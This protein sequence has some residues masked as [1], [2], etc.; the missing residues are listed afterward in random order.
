MFRLRRLRLGLLAQI[1]LALALVGTVPLAIAA[2]QLAD[3]NREALVEQLLRTHTVSARTAADAIDGFLAAR[4]SLAGALRLSPELAAD[5]TSEGGQARLRDSLASW[6]A[7][8]VVAAA[9]YDSSDR[10]IVKVQQK[11]Y[12]AL[13]DELLGSVEA[14]PSGLRTVDLHPWIRIQVAL[15]PEMA[16][17]NPPR[18]DSPSPAAPRPSAGSGTLRLAVDA[19]PLLR[20]LAPDELGD[21]AQLLLL[22]RGGKTLLGPVEAVAALPSALL[23]SALSARLSGSGRFRDRAGHEIVGAWSAADSG[24]WIVVSTQPAA[25]AEAAALRMRQRTVLVVALALALAAA[26]SIFAYRALVRPLR[27]LLAAQR[28]VAGL[29]GEPARGSEVAQLKTTMEALERNARDRSALDEVFLGRYQVVE[30]LGSGGM[31]TV[32][33][34]WDPRLQ[35]AVALKTIHLERRETDAKEKQAASRL[36][37]EAVAAAQIVHPNVVAIYDTEEIG[38]MA[39]VAMEYVHGTGLDRYLEERGKLSWREVLPLGRAICEGLAAA[40]AHDLVHRDIKPG[41]ILLGQDGSIKIADFG[42]ALFLSQRG[43]PGETVVGTPGFLAPEALRGR[44]V[45]AWSDLFAVGVLLCRSLTGHYPFAGRNLR[46]IVASTLN[47]PT[48][49]LDSFDERIPRPLVDLV[50]ALLEKSPERR[51]G[52]ASEVATRLAELCRRHGLSWRLDF[53]RSARSVEADEIFRSVSLPVVP[54]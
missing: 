8:G 11:G 54:E 34:G 50:R 3:V 10:L 20:S 27:A 7:A 15:G 30:I 5:P 2:V 18:A 28:R 4:R 13:A 42:L 16:E 45:T 17:A 53:T 39:Y 40:H 33:R 52:P 38:A 46:A 21:Q 24:R 47:D 19:A 25:I 48:P 23:E 36:V 12:G 35:R 1:G 37:T 9:L 14:S 44:P 22:D 29:S 32:F 31:G 51:L 26:I 41:N 6:S 49:P 43:E